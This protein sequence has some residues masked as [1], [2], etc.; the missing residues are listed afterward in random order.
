MGIILFII[1]VLIVLALACY[2]VSI[3]PLPGPPPIKPCIEVLLV[4]LAIVAIL[5]H[6]GLGNLR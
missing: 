1:V 3:L 4:V 2:C 6:A 5:D